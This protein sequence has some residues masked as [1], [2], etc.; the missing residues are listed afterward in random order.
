MPVVRW[1]PW[2][3]GSCASSRVD[4]ISKFSFLPQKLS[5]GAV[6]PVFA[7]P[8]KN[9]GPECPNP[10][11][12]SSKLKVYS[13]AACRSSELKYPFCNSVFGRHT[14]STLTKWG[15]VGL[16]R[17]M[18]MERVLFFANT[19]S[20]ASPDGIWSLCSRWLLAQPH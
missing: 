17:N 16:D 10:P 13:R 9:W 8:F 4:R 6:L 7:N 3:P 15:R 12:D 2:I 18:N 14:F 20:A 1:L 5:R 19:G 11:P